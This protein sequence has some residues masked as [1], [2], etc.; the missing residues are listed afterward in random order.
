MGIKSQSNCNQKKTP[1][2][3]GVLM[4]SKNN[5]YLFTALVKDLVKSSACVLAMAVI[6]SNAAT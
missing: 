1:I 5:N 2:G 6:D 3:L 4:L